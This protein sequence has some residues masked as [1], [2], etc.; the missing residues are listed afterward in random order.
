MVGYGGLVVG[1]GIE[2]TYHPDFQLF[3]VDLS[4]DQIVLDFRYDYEGSWDGDAS[5]NGPYF[6]D[7]LG[8]APD[9]TGVSINGAT[10]MVGLDSGDLIW[11][12]N[13]ISVDWKGLGIFPGMQVIL[14][15][16]FGRE[17]SVPEA[18]TWA[19]GGALAL[20]MGGMWLRRRA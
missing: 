1:P 15:L 10:T 6:Y 5:F 9:L 7:F 2:A 14:D 8:T 18:S 3:D 20:M 16:Q 19:A 12:A 11:N 4:G 13:E 17:Q